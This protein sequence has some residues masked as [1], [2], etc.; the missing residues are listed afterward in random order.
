VAPG[1]GSLDNEAVD[2]TLDLG[3][4]HRGQDVGGDDGEEHRSL[5]GLAFAAHR[6]GRIE[7]GHVVVAA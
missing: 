7:A 5:Q 3:R 1:N 6:C 4:Q 2:R